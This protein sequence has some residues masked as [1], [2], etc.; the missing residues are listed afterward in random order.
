M[1]GQFMSS[2]KGFTLIEVIIAIFLL[3]VALLGLVSV[4]TTVIKG[5][6]FSQTLT[7]AT[8]LAADKMEELKT[9]SY[10]AL[11]T[12]PPDYASSDGTVSTAGNAYYTRTATIGAVPNNMKSVSVTV[13]WNWMAVSH[14]VT[15][16]TL[17]A[18]RN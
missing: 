14:T 12:E 6:S 3:A 8:T 17:R 2:K 7:M 10:D 1:N 11:T 16:N 5:N 13:T 4:T 15:L 18:K 9:S